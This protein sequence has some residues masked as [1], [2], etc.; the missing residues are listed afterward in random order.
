MLLGSGHSQQSVPLFAA[1]VKCQPDNS[2]YWL[3]L[4]VAQQA[5]G[6]TQD[7]ITSL[8][9]SLTLSPYSSRPYQALSSLYKTQNHPE[10]ARQVL[11]QFLNL[12]PKAS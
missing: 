11:Q 8:T 3:D 5:A 4:G 2:E 12:V 1:A 10:L 6:Q 9:R 7:A